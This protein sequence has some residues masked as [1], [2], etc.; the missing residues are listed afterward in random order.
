MLYTENRR[1]NKKQKRKRNQ[2]WYDPKKGND[3]KE[4]EITCIVKF[5]SISVIQMHY[6]SS[7]KQNINIYVTRNTKEVEF[8]FLYT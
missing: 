8:L 1:D 6:T 4:T 5:H 7:K 2:K 3:S